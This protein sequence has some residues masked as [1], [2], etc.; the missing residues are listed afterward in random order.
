MRECVVVDN[1]HKTGRHTDQV[2]NYHMCGLC[3]APLAGAGLSGSLLLVCGLLQLSLTHTAT[4]AGENPC[5]W[6][7]HT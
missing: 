4:G 7:L 1:T 2:L 3:L 5:L 6:L